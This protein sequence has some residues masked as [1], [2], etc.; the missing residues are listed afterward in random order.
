MRIEKNNLTLVYIS[1]TGYT[2]ELV[3]F[4]RQADLLLCEASLYDEYRGK[5]PGHMT[6]GEA[7]YIAQAA[8]VRHL[9]LTHLPHF[10][11]HRLLVEQARERFTGT[12]ELAKT[13]K[14][15]L[16]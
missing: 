11:H 15:W 5:I 16:L 10:G 13:G 1:D 12:V 7:G 6:A 8:G 4:A 3:H 14:S 2:D 9:V